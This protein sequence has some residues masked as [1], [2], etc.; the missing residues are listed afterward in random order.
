M[1]GPRSQP[2]NDSGSVPA[3]LRRGRPAALTGRRGECDTLDRLIA[4]VRASESR[5]LVVRG[6]PGVGNTALLDYLAGQAA[7]AA[8]ILHNG[9]GR[10]EQALTAARH[11]CQDTTALPISMWA[12]PELVEAAARAGH[13]GLARDALTQLPKSPSRSAPI[14]R[15]ASRR[16]A[17]PCSVTTPAPTTC[18]AR[19]ST[20]WPG[21]GCV[22]NS[23]APTCC[24][25]NGCAARAGASMRAISCAPPTT[26]SP[27]SA[28]G[29]LPSARA[30]S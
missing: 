13:A 23:P 5:A 10:Y 7:D 25:G 20:G 18:T 24:T 9:A 8:A 3:W 29:H 26:L 21:P 11:A 27:R 2:V 17:G 4:A 28:W 16:A 1:A 19:R 6:D 15:S 30:G 14:P 22:P 12:L